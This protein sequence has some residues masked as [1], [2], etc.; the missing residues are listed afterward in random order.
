MFMMCCKQNC[1]KKVL[2]ACKESVW[3]GV[4]G[5]YDGLEVGGLRWL[6]VAE[7]LWCLVDLWVGGEM[8]E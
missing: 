6:S 7:C 3:F 2:Y 5:V 1:N 8:G 4:C